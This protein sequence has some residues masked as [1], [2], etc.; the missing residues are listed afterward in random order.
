[1]IAYPI[2]AGRTITR[3]LEAG[4]AGA[5]AILLVHGL[6]SRADRWVR[7][8]DA[9]AAAGYRVIAADLPGH[10]FA[11][12]DPTADHTIGGYADFILHLLDALHIGQ[13]TLVGTSLGGHVVAAAALRQPRRATRMMMIGSTGFVPSTPERVQSFRNWI[14]NLTPEAHRPMLERVFSDRTLVTDDMVHED[15]RINTSPGAAACFDKFL[16]YMGSGFNDDLVLDRLPGIADAVPLLLLWGVNDS[17]V[18]VEIGRKAR[19][20]LAEARLVCVEGLNHTP[21]YENPALFNHVLLKFI[22]GELA[23][24]TA[25]GLTIT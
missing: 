18:A 2:A 12:K 8:I 21:Y 3:V 15:V 25:S 20:S 11:T 13:A 24:I 14:M 1:M 19:A 17:S 22:A 9:L 23:A 4:A 7:N 5:P 10:G 16:T 6:S